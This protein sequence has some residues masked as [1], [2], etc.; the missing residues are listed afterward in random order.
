MCILKKQLF[1]GKYIYTHTHILAIFAIIINKAL[2][3]SG[4]LTG[5]LHINTLSHLILKTKIEDKGA[6][7]RMEPFS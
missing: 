7:S 4:T 1:P 5:N 6:R 2:L 3:K